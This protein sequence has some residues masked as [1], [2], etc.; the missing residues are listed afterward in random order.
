MDKN[1]LYCNKNM[2]ELKEFDVDFLLSLL[3]AQETYTEFS[4]IMVEHIIYGN[5]GYYEGNRF[6]VVCMTQYCDN[7]FFDAYKDPNV[8]V[9]IRTGLQIGKIFL[10]SFIKDFNAKKIYS[11]HR[12]TNRLATIAL[13]KL[14]FKVIQQDSLMIYFIKYIEG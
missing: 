3:N 13:K 4:G 11:V 10:D 5:T 2:I 1:T 12:I 7:Y 6:G 8:R 14:G 9:P